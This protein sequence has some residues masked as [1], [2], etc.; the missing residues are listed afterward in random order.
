[1]SKVLLAQ[2]LLLWLLLIVKNGATKAR[3]MADA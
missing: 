2:T 1:M 3:M